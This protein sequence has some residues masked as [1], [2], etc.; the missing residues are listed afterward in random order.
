LLGD[1]SV[2]S[3]LNAHYND[4]NTLEIIKK[5]IDLMAFWSFKTLDE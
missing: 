1:R 4:L 2:L 5:K 3:H